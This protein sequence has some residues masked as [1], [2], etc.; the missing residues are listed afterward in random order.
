MAAGCV[1]VEFWKLPTPLARRHA[2]NKRLAEPVAKRAM[3]DGS[4]TGF[5]VPESST[6]TPDGFGI[7]FPPPALLLYATK[8]NVLRP[9][10]NPAFIVNEVKTV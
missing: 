9:D 4:G 10:T 8:S 5:T 7:G 3:V 2:R 1:A 6:R